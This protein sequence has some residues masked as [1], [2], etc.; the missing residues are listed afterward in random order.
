VLNTSSPTQ[1]DTLLYSLYASD[2]GAFH[3]INTSPQIS[4]GSYTTGPGYDEVTGLGSPAADVL[5]PALV[6]TA[7]PI[8]IWDG[9]GADSNWTTAANWVN[10][11][12][13]VA[14][15][16]LVFNGST[17]TSSFNDFPDG[18]SFDSIVFDNG[19]FTLSG[20]AVTLNPQGGI[21]VDNHLGNNEIA[22]SITLG[23]TCT[24]N[25]EAGTLQLD[26]AAQTLVLG[27][28]GGANVT[29][30]AL[31]L[32]YS[33]GSD[34]VNTVLS[35]LN[36]G[37]ITDLAITVHSGP[38]AMALGW[39]DTASQITIEPTLVGD[40]NLSGTVDNND[41][42]QLLKYFNQPGGWAQG[43]FN[44][45]GT[46]DNNDLGALLANFNVS[47]VLPLELTL[48]GVTANAS[49][50]ATSSGT[51]TQIGGGTSAVG[52]GVDWAADFYGN[53]TSTLPLQKQPN[54]LAPA[55]RL[56]DAVFDRWPGT[57]QAHVNTGELLGSDD[58]D[59]AGNADLLRYGKTASADA[60]VWPKRPYRFGA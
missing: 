20:D 30:G 60:A 28:A 13:P 1:T 22:L 27:G 26:S 3:D 50:A 10:D 42:G 55:R 39:S 48:G 31:I 16:R 4:N 8:T 9:G 56:R 46:V 19:G 2:P 44:Y 54:G 23:S 15:D 17:Q 45:N 29:G 35:E 25:V 58:S 40:T 5:I 7:V 33:N 24:T 49:P 18:T 43:D 14:G 21:A 59:P 52:N 34:P 11:I 47:T 32:N 36:S 38:G 6:P 57:S 12:V 41:L 51:G 53:G 37:K